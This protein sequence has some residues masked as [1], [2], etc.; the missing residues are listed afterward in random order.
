MLDRRPPHLNCSKWD[1]TVGTL[2]YLDHLLLANFGTMALS[3]NTTL[4]QEAALY[5]ARSPLNAAYADLPAISE[6]ASLSYFEANLLANPPLQGGIDFALG[7]FA[8]GFGNSNGTLLR[9]WAKQR[10]WPVVWFLGDVTA[11][12]PPNQPFGNCTTTVYPGNERILDPFSLAGV[13]ATRSSK[14]MQ[15]F[16]DLW[17][18]VE[19]ARLKG[20]LQPDMINDYWRKL[21]QDQPRVAPVSAHS[22]ADFPSCVLVQLPTDDC[23]CID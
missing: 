15:A 10:D 19:Q 9:N 7:D 14:V 21:K 18:S 17:A 16:I 13:N 1:T 20:P 22:C 23:I 8:Q 12:M 3:H 11:C 5:F 4:Y 2:D 6:A